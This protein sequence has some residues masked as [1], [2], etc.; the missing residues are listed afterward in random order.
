MTQDVEALLARLDS[1]AHLL[2]LIE[3]EMAQEADEAAAL[4]RKQAGEI[5]RLTKAMKDIAS[6]ST[7][8]VSKAP[9]Q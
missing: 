4:I 5:E 6:R 9:N 8:Y 7:S 1:T 2:G 3:P